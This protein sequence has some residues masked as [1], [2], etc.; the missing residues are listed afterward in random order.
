[1]CHKQNGRYWKVTADKIKAGLHRFEGTAAIQTPNIFTI[2]Y[3]PMRGS[4]PTDNNEYVT[5]TTVAL[6]T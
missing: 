5:P 1:M 6:Q 2:P 4:T 3:T